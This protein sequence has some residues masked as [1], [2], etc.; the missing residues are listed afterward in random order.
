MHA[1]T[2]RLNYQWAFRLVHYFGCHQITQAVISPGSRSSPLALAC[3][4]HPAITTWIAID[5]RSAAF[6]AMGLAQRTQQPVL[7][8][9]TSGT[10]VAN[11]LPAVVEANHSHTPLLLLSADRP[12]ELQ[13]CGANQT[14][15][16]QNLFG[17]QVRTFIQLKHPSQQVLHSDYLAHIVA[18][19]CHDSL[20]PNPGPVHLNIPF[21][22]PLLPQAADKKTLQAQI[23]Q[24]GKDIIK[25]QTSPVCIKTDFVPP[26]P[27]PAIMR[28]IQ[29][30]LDKPRGLIVC[31]R[32]SAAERKKFQAALLRLAATLNC[33]VLLDPLS[34]LRL[35]AQHD[36]LLLMNYDTFLLDQAALNKSSPQWIIH[37]GQFPLSKKLQH[38]LQQQNCQRVLI[39]P[40]GDCPDPL[41]TR[42]ILC[43][44]LPAQFCQ[45]ILPFLYQRTDRYWLELWL[46]AE[47]QAEKR[48]IQSLQA[49]QL[50]EGLVI[51]E[52]LQAIPDQALMFS[53]NSLAI[54]DFDTFICHHNALKTL[55]LYANRGASGID[56]NIS[57]FAGL[58][59]T[60]PTRFGVAV[61]G[62]LSFYHDMN[63]LLLL[64]QLC[65]Q[66]CNGAIILLN[67][68]G[69]GIF[70]YL[71]PRQLDTFEKLW[72]TDTGLAFRHCAALYQLDYLRISSRS[73]L[74]QLST[75]LGQ[76]G[77]TL[78]EVMIDPQI[79]VQCHRQMRNK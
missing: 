45:L 32:L 18:Q 72:Q 10:A 22:E 40:Y 56:G 19:A 2:G 6:F 16:Q 70:Q 38:Y 5:E 54:R 47:Q 53:G 36:P 15:N 1:Q 34:G 33:P 74:T 60:H 65:Q 58:L 66:G 12:D 7:L 14:I 68:H 43:P 28:A 77:F 51:H 61:L 39:N 21:R 17:A 48:I 11:W 8:I 75:A 63:G 37:F 24:L 49:T 13:N 64:K 50:F 73:E 25:I 27:E 30:L 55:P 42:K 35:N 23:T 76:K 26:E 78:I 4:Q 46:H 62:D 29:T 3:E 52:L 69:G 20:S 67:N 71:P 31:G 57:T 59:A 79:S 41:H 9:A 44:V